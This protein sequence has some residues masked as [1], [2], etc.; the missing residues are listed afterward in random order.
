[1]ALKSFSAL[2]AVPVGRSDAVVHLSKRFQFAEDTSLIKFRHSVPDLEHMLNALSNHTRPVH[3]QILGLNC[4][5]IRGVYAI[6]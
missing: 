5:P 3:R 4:Q 1:M 2:A 6:E